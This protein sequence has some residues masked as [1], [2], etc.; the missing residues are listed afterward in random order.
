MVGYEY[1]GT[2]GRVSKNEVA[3]LSLG[4]EPRKVGRKVDKLVRKDCEE[5]VKTLALL[6]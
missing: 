6:A 1:V 2:L 4:A 3:S 5:I